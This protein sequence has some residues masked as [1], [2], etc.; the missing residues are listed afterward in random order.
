MEEKKHMSWYLPQDVTVDFS[1]YEKTSGAASFF[2]LHSHEYYEMEFVTDGE[3]INT[4]NGMAT[5]MARGDL[6]LLSVGDS[7]RLDIHSPRACI[8]KLN[9][10]SDAFSPDMTEVLAASPL[11]L[12]RHYDGEEF[13]ALAADFARVARAAHAASGENALS[14]VALRVAAE[15]L[16]CRVLKNIPSSGPLPRLPQAVREGMRYIRAHLS[17]PLRLPEL[18]AR[19]CLSPGHF[20][21]VFR[22]HTSLSPQ[23]YLRECRMQAA[24]DLLL[25]TDLPVAQVAGRVGYTS[26]SLFYRH[27]EKCYGAK[28]LSLRRGNGGKAPASPSEEG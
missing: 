25:H 2:P 27:M 8:R 16:L 22:A 7:H 10:R 21:H 18:A 9:F 12:S 6:F 5:P 11:P 4:V 3:M 20:S 19:F 1:I 14:R 24:R 15:A 17:E 23:A 13:Y 28:P 26:P